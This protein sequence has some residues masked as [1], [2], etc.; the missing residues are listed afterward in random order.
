MRSAH[1]L[2][3]AVVIETPGETKPW[4]QATHP[5]QEKVVWIIV[6]QEIT[7]TEVGTEGVTT[8]EIKTDKTSSEAALQQTS[9]RELIQALLTPITTEVVAAEVEEEAAM[10]A[11]VLTNEAWAVVA[12]AEEATTNPETRA[13]IKTGIRKEIGNSTTSTTISR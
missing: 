9:F 4:A 7:T 3:L 12:Q 2:N 1:R 10:A 13:E 8:S 6:S 5:T 11:M